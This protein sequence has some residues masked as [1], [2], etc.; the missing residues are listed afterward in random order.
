M[1]SVCEY[2]EDVAAQS[3]FPITLQRR[4]LK[5]TSGIGR[6][7]TR[8]EKK[9]FRLSASPKLDKGETELL[10]MACDE[11]QKQYGEELTDLADEVEAEL[12]LSATKQPGAPLDLPS[13]SGLVEALL[14]GPDDQELTPKQ[15][16][17]LEANWRPPISMSGIQRER[18][19]N[20]GRSPTLEKQDKLRRI[21]T[22]NK[23]LQRLAA[24]HG[25]PGASPA[26]NGDR[27]DAMDNPKGLNKETSADQ[28]PPAGGAAGAKPQ[29]KGMEPQSWIMDGVTLACMRSPSWPALAEMVKRDGD[30]PPDLFGLIDAT[31]GEFF[32]AAKATPCPPGD[33]LSAIHYWRQLPKLHWLLLAAD[34]G[35]KLSEEN[36]KLLFDRVAAM[37]LSHSMAQGIIM[38][39]AEHA[40]LDCSSIPI[41]GEKCLDLIR[42]HPELGKLG[43]WPS[44]LDVVD[45]KTDPHAM[46]AIREAERIITR[47]ETQLR[48]ADAAV[49]L[50]GPEAP[51]TVS[52]LAGMKTEHDDPTKQTSNQHQEDALPEYVTLDQAAATVNRSK[53]S[54]ERLKSKMPAPKIR[55]GGGKPDEWDWAEIRPWLIKEFG[56]QLPERFPGRRV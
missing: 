47:L 20:A 25:S 14:A 3:G 31:W 4:I 35:K 12:K 43:D 56:R 48:A 28:V 32:N 55:G 7:F 54:L 52:G 34:R 2:L 39:A 22:Y 37:F 1:L 18:Q 17:Y 5:V 8:I 15:I 45:C 10:K 23:N 27:M 11:L 44:F 42:D 30:C 53:R 51:V 19:N 33:V 21:L 6:E 24:Q 36:D 9:Y 49:L 46:D 26:A 50:P 38:A 40:G 29:A 41:S 16:A 13:G